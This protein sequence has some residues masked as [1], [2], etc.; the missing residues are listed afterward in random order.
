M[1]KI[2]LLLLFCFMFSNCSTRISFALYNKSNDPVTFIFYRSYPKVDSPLLH[3]SNDTLLIYKNDSAYCWFPG[4]SFCR[5]KAIKESG[6]QV[7]DSI[8]ISTDNKTALY[9]DKNY[10]DSLLFKNKDTAN[11]IVTKVRFPLNKKL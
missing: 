4:S 11:I 7:I 10:I 1:R 9:Q 8:K 5:Y 3:K 6:L 2:L